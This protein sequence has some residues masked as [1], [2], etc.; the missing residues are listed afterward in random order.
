MKI[1]IIEDDATARYA[2]HRAV[3]G[4]G[5]EIIEAD[6]GQRG[7]DLLRTSSAD[8]VFLD[9]NMPHR[10]GLSILAEMRAHPDWVCP[11]IVVLTAN[12]N[13][14]MAV[15]C[16]R[17][18]A[19]DFITKPY[20][21]EQVRSIVSRSQKRFELEQHVAQLSAQIESVPQ[22]GEMFSVSA[23]MHK[24]FEQVRRAAVSSL[25]ILIRGES[26]TGKEL[27][28]R[29]LHRLSDR[30]NKPFVAVNTAAISE[31]L[32]ESELFGHIRGAF[33]GADRNR[34]GVFRKANGG[35][36]FLDEIGDMPSGVQ[37][38]LLR[39]LQEGTM[40]PVGSEDTVTVDVRVL[41]ATHQDLESAM[42]QNRFRSDLYYRLR[43][44]ELRLPP[45]RSRREDI[46]LLANRFL[47]NQHEFG[48]DCFAPML[49]HGWH[50]NVRELKQRVEGAAAM[51]SERMITPVD[52]GLS[53]FE[54]SVNED[55]SFSEYF[56]MPLTEAKQL[57]VERYEQKAIERALR[58]E[59]NNI[60][61]AARRLGIHRQNLQTK[62]KNAC[63]D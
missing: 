27:V 39:I 49:G 51:A 54:A 48:V 55:A 16:I 44:I 37:T 9:L 33:T 14:E 24:V 30:S 23:T 15:E 10:D 3:R 53:T 11:E 36:L 12:D 4:H 19:A 18:G 46:L 1:L 28:A 31:S 43:G 5:R 58:L 60:S 21:I 42:E 61:A 38:R 17:R 20:E 40:T 2:L 62:L 47:G 59:N 34:E 29:E 45:L 26:G 7:L 8:L 63:D 35:T 52:L 13:I 57:L 41:S 22:L 6:D 25:P 32:I 56:D 50:G